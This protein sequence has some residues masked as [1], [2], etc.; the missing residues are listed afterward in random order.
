MNLIANNILYH[1]R[2]RRKILSKG[3]SRFLYQILHEIRLQYYVKKVTDL[4]CRL[5]FQRSAFERD[6]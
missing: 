3:L 4:V 6:R 5:L 1:C 2:S